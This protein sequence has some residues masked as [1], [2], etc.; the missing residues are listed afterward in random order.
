MQDC[1]LSYL[2][3]KFNDML[4][5]IINSGLFFLFGWFLDALSSTKLQL[6]ISLLLNDCNM[7]H[8]LGEQD[9]ILCIINK[10]HALQLKALG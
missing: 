6:L 1:L 2:L 7:L 8:H 4:G 10:S 5:R 9:L 3:L